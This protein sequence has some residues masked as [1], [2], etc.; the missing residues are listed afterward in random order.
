MLSFVIVILVIALSGG[1]VAERA[2]KKSSAYEVTINYIQTDPKIRAECG[3]LQKTGSFISGS[4][5]STRIEGV[6]SGEA[7]YIITC[8]FSKGKYRI[9]VYLELLEDGSE[10]IVTGSNIKKIGK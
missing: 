8:Y 6:Y 5:E 4:M 9:T 2:M 10:W 1:I 3:E 7:E